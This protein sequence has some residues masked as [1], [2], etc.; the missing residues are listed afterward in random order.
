MKKV[1]CPPTTRFLL[2]LS[3]VCLQLDWDVFTVCEYET[4]TAYPECCRSPVYVLGSACFE[5]VLVQVCHVDL[6]C[7][8]PSCSRCKH[9]VGRLNIPLTPVFSVL[10][11]HFGVWINRQILVEVQFCVSLCFLPFVILSQRFCLLCSVITFFT[12][13]H[14]IF[15]FPPQ[16]WLDLDPV[17]TLRTHKFFICMVAFVAESSWTIQRIIFVFIF[18]FLSGTNQDNGVGC[19]LQTSVSVS[20]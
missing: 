1:S 11:T 2:V 4:R 13:C 9:I 18:L 10:F 16:P 20:S 6:T 5:H 7:K 14:L 3:S 12:V 8:P 17:F 19:S 15:H